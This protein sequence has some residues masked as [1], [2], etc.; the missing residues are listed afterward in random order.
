M[1]TKLV[2]WIVSRLLSLSKSSAVW[3]VTS[4]PTGRSS[5]WWRADS[6][7]LCRLLWP[8]R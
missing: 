5:G 3:A 4:D 1:K 6:R 7:L 2:P 8:D